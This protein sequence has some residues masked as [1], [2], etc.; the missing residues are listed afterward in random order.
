MT[1]SERP[2][3]PFQLGSPAFTGRAGTFFSVRDV[4][5]GRSL[6]A[7]VPSADLKTLPHLEGALRAAA[8]RG[9]GPE[10]VSADLHASSPHLLLAPPPSMMNDLRLLDEAMMS[11]LRRPSY[12]ADYPRPPVRAA[13]GAPPA[14]T[15]RRKRLGPVLVALG[16][17]GTC[18]VATYFLLPVNV[19]PVVP[20]ASG[21]VVT[22]ASNAA[23]Y[24]RIAPDTSSVPGVPRAKAPP[25]GSG[26]LVPR[27]GLVGLGGACTA[28][29]DCMG[30]SRCENAL[31]SC[32]SGF[33]QVC[34]G[35][36]FES[37]DNDHCGSCSTVCVAGTHC[38][39]FDDEYRC[40]GCV[41]PE[42]ACGS[43]LGCYHL[44]SDRNNC[45]RCGN[46]CGANERCSA[47]DC[48]RQ[49]T[50]GGACKSAAECDAVDGTC[51]KDRCR[52]DERHGAVGGKC[53]SCP[54]GHPSINDV[55]RTP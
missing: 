42:S 35:R 13:T 2:P 19:A 9:E 43:R 23:R 17:F 12:F 37:N 8:Q 24:I 16:V 4:R 28:S 36:C 47:G 34:G 38:S 15:A 26:P 50:L 39:K 45:G 10:L 3:A 18:L 51:F 54:A 30:G 44:D 46:K 20:A 55:C 7:L 11:L 40:I 1:S 52:C 25:S 49:A 22:D 53:V 27:A 33:A 6:F 14:E 48:L 21:V 5:S 41:A 29:N 31:C 32:K